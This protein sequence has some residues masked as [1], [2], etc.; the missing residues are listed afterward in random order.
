MAGDDGIDILTT[1]DPGAIVG[2]ITPKTAGILVAPVRTGAT[3]DVLPGSL[4]AELRTAADEYGIVLAFDETASGLCRAGMMWAHEWT[5]VTPDLMIVG[6]GLAGPVP[7]AA[8]LAT[9]K[10]ARGA[11]S[12]EPVDPAAVALAHARLDTILAVGFDSEVQSRAWALEDRLTVL[13]YQQR[14]AFTATVGLGLMQALV[15]GADAAPLAARA[16]AAGLLTRPMGQVL[17]L[18][19]P[20]T[21]SEAEIDAAADILARIAAEE[22]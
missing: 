20:L 5:G 11:V 3:L 13:S 16:A 15:C 10:V 8:V 4:L 1:D 7:L 6:A 17:G 21:V 18:F 19:P 9:R 2:A 14:P 12:P 22:G